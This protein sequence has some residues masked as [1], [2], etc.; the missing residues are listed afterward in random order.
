MDRRFA[1]QLDGIDGQNAPL[2]DLVSEWARINS[3]SLHVAGLEA[4]AEAVVRELGKLDAD[5]RYADLPP[6]RVLDDSGAT[7]ERW[8]GRAVRITQRPH[9][10]RRVLL[11]IHLDTVYG[12]DD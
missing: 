2:R 4:C 12:P 10:P 6:Q 11:S 5:V 7:A 3:G 1:P 8:L 9:A